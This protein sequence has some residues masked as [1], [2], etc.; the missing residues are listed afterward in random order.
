MFSLPSN[1]YQVKMKTFQRINTFALY[2]VWLVFLLLADS[3]IFGQ[4]SFELSFVTEDQEEIFDGVVDD[5]GCAYFTGRIYDED[6]S[7][8]YDPYILKVYPNG[9][10]LSKRIV[11]VDTSAFFQ[12]IQILN[13]GSVMLLGQCGITDS[14]GFDCLY[15][16]KTDT[17]LNVLFT[18]AYNLSNNYYFGF[19][20]P[21]SCIDT[22]Q[23]IIVAGSGKYYIGN[24][25]YHSDFAFIK[26]NQQGDTLITN[27][28]HYQFSQEVNDIKSIP[29]TKDYLCIGGNINLHNFGPIRL[30][31]SLNI[32]EIKNFDNDILNQGCMEWLT[33]TSY[34]FTT[35]G[36]SNLKNFGSIA[37]YILDTSLNYHSQQLLGK[38]DTNDF[39]ALRQSIGYAN[40][41][42]IYIGGMM[43]T[44]VFTIPN[45]WELYVIDRELNLLGYKE[46][47]D[48][49]ATYRLSGIVPTPDMGCIMYGSRYAEETNYNMD[50]H[51]VKIR[52]EDIEIE[53]SPITSINKP[54]RPVLCLGYPNPVINMLNIP[55]EENTVLDGCRLQIFNYGGKVMTDRALL[56]YGNILQINVSN[57]NPG[58]YIFNIITPEN[59]KINGKFLKQ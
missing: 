33:D 2:L 1:L 31:S 46:V 37:T 48:Y 16:C 58:M 52:R 5:Q 53:T 43:H 20:F 32:I 56:G 9:D 8:G 41:T 25:A 7:A 29:G 55:L 30:D 10:T 39:P 54:A 6:F 36:H 45:V 27:I 24:P 22:D 15:V 13:D 23:N 59:K 26:L 17:A 50:V 57:L 49:L 34:L 28:P 21:Q 35:L 38:P 14:A 18:K 4:H 40:D 42:T 44:I 3:T 11:N 12:S 47:G 19:G 51:I